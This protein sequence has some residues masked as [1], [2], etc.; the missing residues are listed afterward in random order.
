MSRLE[1]LTVRVLNPLT[2]FFIFV[3][4]LVVPENVAQQANMTAGQ[5]SSGAGENRRN[6]VGT[7]GDFIR[8]THID[9]KN[10]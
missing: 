9:P 10:T 2:L 8:C 4:L 5:Q 3:I 7:W 1:V 6:E